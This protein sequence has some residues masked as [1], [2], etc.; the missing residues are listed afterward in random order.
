LGAC[1]FPEEALWPV[2]GGQT[3][4]QTQ[5][6][7]Q[8]ASTAT[9]DPE[10]ATTSLPLGQERFTPPG[11]SPGVPRETPAVDEVEA[12]R[13]E[14]GGLQDRLAAQDERLHALRGE[15]RGNG[16]AYDALTAALETHLQTGAEPGAAELVRLWN[17]AEGE[18]AATGRSLAALNGLSNDAT[19]TA[20]RAA[21]L[22]ASVR[23]TLNRGVE[24]E[25]DRREL[26]MLE[27]E[28]GDTV[29]VSGGLAAPWAWPGARPTPDRSRSRPA[30]PARPWSGGRCPWWLS[31]STT[32]WSTTRRRYTAQCAKRCDGA[33]GRSSTWWP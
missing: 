26:V 3:T 12:L 13:V 9:E 31:A 2:E 25:M 24:H 21:F 33:P 6:A 11:V 32:P 5:A 17:E 27:G 28:A 4:T 16:A 8:P 20:T 10:P 15:A 1:G 19:A 18:L 23:G 30:S 14:L 29:A 7:A 22:L